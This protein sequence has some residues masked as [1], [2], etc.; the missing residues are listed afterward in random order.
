MMEKQQLSAGVQGDLHRFGVQVRR[1]IWF[2]L[3][4]QAENAHSDACKIGHR[5]IFGWSIEPWIRKDFLW[6]PARFSR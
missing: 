3:V 2:H 5:G 4:A 1:P 6:W